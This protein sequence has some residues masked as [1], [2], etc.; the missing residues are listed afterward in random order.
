MHSADYQHTHPDVDRSSSN[1]IEIP[2]KAPN[3]SQNTAKALPDRLRSP[4]LRSLIN[5]NILG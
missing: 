3:T 2:R 4:D 1:Y 5:V